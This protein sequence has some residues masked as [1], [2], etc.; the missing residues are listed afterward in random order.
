MRWMTSI[1]LA[2][3][4]AS[5]SNSSSTTI[6]AA[7]AD[8]PNADGPSTDAALSVCTGKLYDACNPAASNCMAGLMCKNFAGSVFS[9]C[10]QTCGTCPNQGSTTVMC[11]NMGLCKPSAPNSDCTS[12]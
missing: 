4:L 8:A 7:P 9:V 3:V 2:L 1:L 6:D 5:C 10:T 11:N 12:P